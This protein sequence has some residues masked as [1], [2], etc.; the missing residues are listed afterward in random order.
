MH[1]KEQVHLYA[2]LIVSLGHLWFLF[3]RVYAPRRSRRSTNTPK[4]NEGN[5]PPSLPYRLGQKGIHYMALL[6]TRCHRY[7][8]RG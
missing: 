2:A 3:L 1:K 5:I 8:A 7:W 6:F 4:K